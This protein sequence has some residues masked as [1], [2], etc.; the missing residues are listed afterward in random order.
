MKAPN[1]LFSLYAAIDAHPWRTVAIALAV[2]LAAGLV[3]RR[4][5]VDDNVAA[6]LPGGPGSPGEAAQ[7]LSEFGALDTLLIDL[8]LPG[9]STQ[10]LTGLG[11]TLVKRLRETGQLA[12]IY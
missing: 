7:L 8:S 5:Q 11:D 3:A 12:D 6:L 1:R 9:A 10:E 2:L 4:V